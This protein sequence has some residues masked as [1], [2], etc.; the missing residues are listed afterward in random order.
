MRKYNIFAYKNHNNST[1][2]QI[3]SQG[4]LMT[5]MNKNPDK[6]LLMIIDML[7][8]YMEYLYHVN[9]ANNYYHQIEIRT[10]KLEQ[11]LYI[12]NKE[13]E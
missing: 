8:T 5:E 10:L 9:K 11:D 13:R 1:V 12:S 4:K 7:K 2:Q 6:V 3:N